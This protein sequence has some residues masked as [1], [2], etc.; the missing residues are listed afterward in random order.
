LRGASEHCLTF[1]RP[2]A[3]EERLEVAY[4]RSAAFF[5]DQSVTLLRSEA[6]AHGGIART[7]VPVANTP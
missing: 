4:K 5:K 7:R 2:H 3:L 1:S 6:F